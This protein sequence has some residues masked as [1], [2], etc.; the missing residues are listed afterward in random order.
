MGCGAGEANPHTS[1][2]IELAIAMEPL[3]MRGD[4]QERYN[5]AYAG[6]ERDILWNLHGPAPGVVAYFDA[7]AVQRGSVLVPGCG[8]GYDAIFLAQRGFRVTGV[9]LSPNAIRKA[10]AKAQRK[11]VACRFLLEDF[12]NL[13]KEMQQTFDYVVEVANYHVMR[14]PQRQRFLNSMAGVLKA[15]G[16]MVLIC[17]RYDPGRNKRYPHGLRQASVVKEVQAIFRMENLSPTTLYAG[18]IADAF[19]LVARK[20]SED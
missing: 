18:G 8:L 14:H 11:G 13:P 9:D 4:S 3:A 20:T 17:L 16:R 10:R 6:P 2:A 15:G 12:L 5:R 1:F 7:P 19:M